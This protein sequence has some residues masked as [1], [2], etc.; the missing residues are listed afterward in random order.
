MVQT[1][2]AWEEYL[3]PVLG[4]SAGRIPAEINGNDI[5]KQS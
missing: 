2:R 5:S 3:V 1:L 4:F